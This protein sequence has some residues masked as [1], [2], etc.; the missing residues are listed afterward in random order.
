MRAVGVGADGFDQLAEV[1]IGGL[2][3]E[4]VGFR[5]Q[6]GDEQWLLY[7]A[8]DVPRN[9]TLLGCNVACEFLLGRI[10]HSG[11]VARTVEIE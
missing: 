10:K 1:V 9:R 5:V 6:A 2:G 7:R 8:L 4:A 3:D 11:A